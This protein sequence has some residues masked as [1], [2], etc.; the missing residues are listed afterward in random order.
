MRDEAV[1]AVNTLSNML[2]YKYIQGL[3]ASLEIVT[4]FYFGAA[5][6]WFDALGPEQS[7][8]VLDMTCILHVYFEW[9][10]NSFDLNAI[11]CFP[12]GL[13]SN[14]SA[15]VQVIRWNRRVD[16]KPLPD[17]QMILTHVYV[18]KT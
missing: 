14:T 6:S 9:K 18:T 17:S 7:G 4:Y 11:K 5:T 16:D 13:I 10:F 15:L 12:L 8:D 1:F 2:Y 3:P